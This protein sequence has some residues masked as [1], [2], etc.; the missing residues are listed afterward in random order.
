MQNLVIL[1]PFCTTR[2]KS[3]QLVSTAPDFSWAGDEAIRFRSFALQTIC[4]FN[5]GKSWNICEG[6]RVAAAFVTLN[7]LK[8]HIAHISQLTSFREISVGVN[9]PAW[10]D[11]HPRGLKCAAGTRILPKSIT[12]VTAWPGQN[13][14][15]FFFLAQNHQGFDGAEPVTLHV[16]GPYQRAGKVLGF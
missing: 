2:T 16:H 3:I 1:D 8:P 14:H 10:I 12:L 11:T 6:G 4:F 9:Q 13:T 5:T 15:L 7:L